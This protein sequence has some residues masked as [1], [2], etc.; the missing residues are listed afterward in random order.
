MAKKW[1]LFVCFMV[2]VCT[3][4]YIHSVPAVPT[5]IIFK[6]PGGESLTVWLRGDEKVHWYETSDGYTL[7]KNNRGYLCYAVQDTSGQLTVSD[8]VAVDIDQRDA[9]VNVF[10]ASVGKELRYSKEQT[11]ALKEIWAV[12]ER[13]NKSAKSYEED[14]VLGKFKVVCA[15][16]EYPEREMVKTKEEF[17]AL[18]TQVGYSN[19]GGKGSV[20]DYFLAASY[21]KMELN[22]TVVGPYKAPESSYYYAGDGGT[23]ETVR[24]LA[25]WAIEQAD[26]EVD[27]SE[28]DGDGNGTIDGFHFIFA[29]HG[30]EAGAARSIWSHKWNFR[31]ELTFDGKTI[32]T[33]ACSP[34]LSGNM[35]ES[36]TSIGV[37][38]HEMT[39]AFSAPDFYDT[40][41]EDGGGFQGTGSWD[42]MASGSWNGSPQGSQ[43]SMINMYQKVKFKWVNPIE[44]N[45]PMT[46]HNVN[47]SAESPTAYFFRTNTKG[48]YFLI[49]NRQKVGFD[50]AIPGHGLIIYRISNDLRS[51]NMTH[52][53]GIYPVCASSRVLLPN[54]QP[55]SYG[56][57]NSGGCPF[58]GS[59]NKDSFTDE[60]T[61]S[62]LSWTGVKSDKPMT[63]IVEDANAMTVSFNFMGGKTSD[64]GDFPINLNGIFDHKNKLIELTWDKADGENPTGYNVYRKGALIAKNITETSYIDKEELIYGYYNY[65][66]TAIYGDCE[67]YPSI[68]ST[69]RVLKNPVE[70]VVKINDEN[71]GTIS[72]A[73]YYE[74]GEVV[75]LRH[76]AND[77]YKLLNWSIND[78]VVSESPS[79]VLKA[80]KNIDITATFSRLTKVDNFSKN[81]NI[82][83]K[84]GTIF[85]S[86]D[87]A[88][89]GK[90]EIID[91]N[92]HSVKVFECMG[93]GYSIS[94]RLPHKG[95]YIVRFTST[96]GNITKKI[97]I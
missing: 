1:L 16:V 77:G 21:G 17:E 58:P 69:I 92:G 90:V 6:Q 30:M 94:V 95:L 41:Y 84:N 81:I 57:I 10:L 68:Q 36:M 28:Y 60:T 91:I 73:G 22:V 74:I 38:C 20:R 8:V 2:G 14:G 13:M 7:M 79:Y 5:S 93:G 3:S 70:I 78:T 87:Y 67:S 35:S 40:D 4:S 86:S 44:L 65:S 43:P 66:V 9:K 46:I 85:V 29:G 11:F 24:E 96:D 50:K 62:T 12:T 59:S 82:Y 23:K 31:S 48:E 72:G 88:S 47:N 49:E 15:L 61:P 26:K 71:A 33:Y 75:K 18:M 76:T 64:C 55:S 56:N 63:N 83:S 97:I 53:Q 51:M 80:D 52:P 34:E 37:I 45:S 42:L 54:E 27:F 25:Q 19:N 89:E 39:H 32:D